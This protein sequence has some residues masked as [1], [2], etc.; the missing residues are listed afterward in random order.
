M[1]LRPHQQK[2]IEMVRDSLRTGHMRPL[3]AAPCSYGKTYVAL[4]MM[5]AY[6]ET[7]RRSVFFADRVKLV[8]QTADTLDRMGIDYSVMQADDPRWD[9]RKLIQ[10]ASI[11]TAVNRPNFDFHFAVVD[12][13]HTVYKGFKEKYL[14]RYDAIPFVALSAT[15]FS[16]ALGQVWDDLLIP[17]TSEELTELGYLAPIDYYVGSSVDTS[18]IRT[19]RLPTGGTEFNPNDLGAA[20]V[21]DDQLSGDIVENYL[22]HSPDGS[23]RAIAFC[24][25]IDHSKTLVDKF[26]AHPSGIKARHI[27][28]YTEEDLRRA[29]YADHKAGL[30]SVLS[31]SRLLGTG[32]DA[33]YVEMLIDCYP[34]KS[35][36]DFVQRCGRVA[37]ISPETGKTRA[38]YLDHA[39]NITRHGQLPDTIVPYQLDDGTK[40]YNEDRLIEQE[41]RQ[42]VLRP[43]PVCTTQMSGRRCKACG[44]ELPVDSEIYTDN[45]IL[46]KIERENMPKPEQFSID[47][48]SRWL[49]ELYHYANLKGFKQGWA[50][51]KY[52][53]KFGVAPARV[54][55][56]K[57]DGISLEVKN[58]ITSRNIANAHRRAR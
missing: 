22:K 10:I 4:T 14:D 26:N 48:K 42:P 28:G 32:Y 11:Q 19:M 31:C 18:G 49:S 53:E 33:P 6:A 34:C 2:G 16:K 35:K 1:E 50:H 27:D 56:T 58:W 54:N 52:Q 5:L 15:P 20:M 39:G 21:E 9:P 55:L 17:I 51:Y 47:D 36:I 3:L 41:E 40:R 13:A 7:G 29:L 43:C 8:Q 57:V 24:P 44:Y 46:K 30:F 45:E 38:I 12:E 25:T 37:R 23:K